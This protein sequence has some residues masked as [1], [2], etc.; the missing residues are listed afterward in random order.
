[1]GKHTF[2]IG[3][4]LLASLLL[5]AYTA[6]EVGKVSKK[7]SEVKTAVDGLTEPREG[8]NCNWPHACSTRESDALVLLHDIRA[9]ADA[10][11]EASDPDDPLIMPED[12]ARIVQGF[13]RCIDPQLH[14]TDHPEVHVCDTS[15]DNRCG[16]LGALHELARQARERTDPP[17]SRA[18]WKLCAGGLE[19]YPMDRTN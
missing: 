12:H 15:E 9:W 3:I 17:E 11:A 1:M 19:P 14:C 6:N 10:D 13:D 18:K 7:V 2:W 8:N 4:L 16:A 5:G